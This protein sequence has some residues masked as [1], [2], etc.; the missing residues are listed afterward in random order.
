MSFKNKRLT[1]AENRAW[2]AKNA[3]L[4]NCIPKKATVEKFEIDGVAVAW[5]RP[6]TAAGEKITLHFHGGG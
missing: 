2:S 1:I 3:Q 6:S 4:T 5:I